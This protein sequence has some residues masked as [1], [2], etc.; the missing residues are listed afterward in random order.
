MYV[1]ILKN[2]QCCVYIFKHVTNI[3]F[4]LTYI[5]LDNLNDLK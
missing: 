3:V 4:F 5:K 2:K 1:I